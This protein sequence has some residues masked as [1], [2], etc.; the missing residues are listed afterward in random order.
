MTLFNNKQEK[1][2]EIYTTP[3]LLI[4]KQENK[5]K[6]NFSL[7]NDLEKSVKL[8]ENRIN[9]LR[10]TYSTNV[11]MVKKD[12]PTTET[13]DQR[14]GFSKQTKEN[15]AIDDLLEVKENV[16]NKKKQKNVC[17]GPGWI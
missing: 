3:T 4:N 10:A 15:Y 12:E 1:S 13:K 16:N 6:I 7:M 8:L 2:Q 9:R 17:P 14:T 5:M 11:T